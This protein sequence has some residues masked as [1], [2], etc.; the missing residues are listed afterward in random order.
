VRLQPILAR[1]WPTLI[2][3]V[4]NSE[5]VRHLAGI[6]DRVLG[7]QTQVNVFVGISYNRNQA[8]NSDSWWACIAIRNT[9]PPNPP[10]NAPATW[11]ACTVIGEIAKTPGGRYTRL[12]IPLV[13]NTIWRVPTTLLYHPEP[14]PVLQPPLP[15]TFDV[16]IERVRQLIVDTR[17]P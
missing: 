2:L 7:H 8:R 12:Q 9:N 3:E 1:G 6:R 5:S 16:D 4:G 14:I 10:P 17:L 11:P 15:Q 13:G